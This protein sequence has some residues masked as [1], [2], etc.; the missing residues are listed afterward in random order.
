VKKNL[1]VQA[2]PVDETLRIMKKYNRLRDR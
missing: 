1:P 2:L